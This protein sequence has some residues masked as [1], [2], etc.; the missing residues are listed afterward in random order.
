MI[1]RVYNRVPEVGH[2]PACRRPVFLPPFAKQVITKRLELTCKRCGQGKVVIVREV[3]N[4]L[5]DQS[6]NRD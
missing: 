3:K 4:A 5:L 2:C 6:L 1:E